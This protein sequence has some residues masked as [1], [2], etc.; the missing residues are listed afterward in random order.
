[1]TEPEFELLR[2]FSKYANIGEM[3]N[4]NSQL[5]WVL[6]VPTVNLIYFHEHQ[7]RYNEKLIH[8]MHQTYMFPGK[9]QESYFSGYIHTSPGS[10][11]TSPVHN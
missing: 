10:L 5:I 8:G 3:R 11:Y 6:Y 9:M 7:E 2:T 4:V 1:M